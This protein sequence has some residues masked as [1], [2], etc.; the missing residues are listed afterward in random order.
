MK[1]LSSQVE[2]IVFAELHNILVL[3]GFKADHEDNMLP[4]D[5]LLTP[6]FLFFVVAGVKIITQTIGN[7]G[8]I[9]PKPIT[10]QTTS[11][12]SVVMVTCVPSSMVMAGKP[13]VTSAGSEI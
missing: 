2:Y 7:S 1:Y 3:M 12:G 6:C 8:K 9:V 11:G 10:I 13:I 5:E 4:D